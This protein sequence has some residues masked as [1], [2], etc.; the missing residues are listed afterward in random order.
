MTA[1]VPASTSDIE[2][3]TA[4]R[5]HERQLAWQSLEF[6]SFIHFGMNTMTDREWGLGHED[7]ALFDPDALDVDQWMRAIA[8]AGMRGV[9]LTA[10]HHDGFCLWPTE[11]T[12]HSVAASPWRGGQ[13]D[14]VADVAESARRHGLEFGVYLSPWDR[15]DPTY[16][17]GTAYDDVF[18]AQLT[19]LLTRYGRVFSVWFDGANGE[20]PDGRV[21]TYDWDRYYEAIRRLQ[22]D[23]VIS[24]CGPDV[25]WCGNEAGHTRTNEWSVVPGS[26][27]DIERIADKSQQVDDGE[28]SRLVRSNDDDLGSREALAGHLDDLVW[29]P[30]EVNTSNRPGWFHHPAEDDAVR[31]A[32]E[33]FDIWCGSVGGNATFLLNVP[34]NAHGLVAEPDVRELERLGRLI[35]GFRARVIP[36]T[37]T[38]SSTAPDASAPPTGFG[39]SPDASWQPETIDPLPAVTVA[40]DAPR[41]VEAV[42]LSED[43]RL[44][45]RIER[46][47]VHASVDGRAQLVGEALSVGYRR[48]IR[49]DRPIETD[50]LVVTIEE[51]RGTPVVAAIAAIEA[52]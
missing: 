38:P 21:Q 33:L 45:Q 43:I 1:P 28:F 48:V 16:G 23:A 9:I 24:V 17:S 29:Y 2:I 7:P 3:L 36:S 49:L 51:S 5:P 47:T 40:F 26:L 27:R 46:V 52:G 50:R 8:S 4:V 30:A 42:V 22:P 15:T 18:V 11:T 14:L 19:E 13:G 34:P 20:G 12:E 44:G 37:L 41:A 25:R 39:P 31:T 35:A 10:K 32:E 6:Y